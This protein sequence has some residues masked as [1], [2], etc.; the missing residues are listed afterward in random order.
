MK[1]DITIYTKS[2]CPNCLTAKTLLKTKGLPY[3]ELW[4]D[5]NPLAEQKM[6]D[7]N[8]RQMP[9]IYINNQFVGGLAGLQAALKQ[10]G[11]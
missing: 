9:A 11:L 8:I 7:A 6:R 5:A 1:L 3:T 4:V 10:V 2:N